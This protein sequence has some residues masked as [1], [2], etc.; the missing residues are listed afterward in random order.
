MP[1]PIAPPLPGPGSYEL[2]D[3]EGPNKHYMSSA[4]FVSTT[5]RWS[6]NNLVGKEQL[7]GPGVY[8]IIEHGT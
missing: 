6:G 8:N 3:Y 7:P 5:S 4:A 1:L 2:V